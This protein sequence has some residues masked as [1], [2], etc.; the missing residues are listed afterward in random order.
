M[1]FLESPIL[2]EEIVVEN[3]YAIVVLFIV[4]EVLDE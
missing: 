2:L 3:D 4:S 1:K